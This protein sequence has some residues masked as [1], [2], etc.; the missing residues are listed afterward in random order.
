[1]LLPLA[2]VAAVAA[3]LTTC[4]HPL[5][6]GQRRQQATPAGGVACL[7]C[8]TSPPASTATTGATAMPA[9]H[10]REF[11]AK[12]PSSRV[13]GDSRRGGQC[14]RRRSKRRSH[15]LRSVHIG[16]RPWRRRRWLRLDVPPQA[17]AA[18]TPRLRRGRPPP[19]RPPRQPMPV[20]L[21]LVP[22]PPILRRLS[23][24][25]CAA[26]RLG[27][28]RWRLCPHSCS[29]L[30]P[31]YSSGSP[32]ARPLGPCAGSTRAATIAAVAPLLLPRRPPDCS[33]GGSRAGPPRVVTVAGAAPPLRLCHPRRPRGRRVARR[34]YLCRARRC[35]CR[36]FS[37]RR[38][39]SYAPGSVLRL[40]VDPATDETASCFFLNG[41]SHGWC[42]SC[43]APSS[44][45]KPMCKPLMLV[46]SFTLRHKQ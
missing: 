6:H 2:L 29:A 37:H 22:P 33:A 35:A 23:V 38:V 32:P 12:L 16:G 44:C 14:C 18:H 1:M 20:V 30:L 9:L 46:I 24:R 41:R 45:V 15:H 4:L 31:A 27:S 11:L 10:R 8:F 34:G 17:G 39:L 36:C 40:L 42:L 5:G 19:G 43:A 3:L 21:S 26:P 7:Q 28:R 13:G 25:S